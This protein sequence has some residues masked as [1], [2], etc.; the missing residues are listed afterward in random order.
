MHAGDRPRMSGVDVAQVIEGFFRTAVRRAKSDPASSADTTRAAAS[1]SPAQVPDRPLNRTD[2]RC[3][4]G[5]RA[6][7]PAR[8][9]SSP[10]ALRAEFPYQRLGP[11]RLAGARGPG[12]EDVLAADDG[13]AHELPRNYPTVEAEQLTFRRIE[14]ARA[15]PR[16]AKYAAAA[17]VPSIDQTASLGRRIAIATQPAAGRRRNHDLYRAH[18]S[19]VRPTAAVRSRRCADGWRWRAS[20][21]GALH[22]SKSANASVLAAPAGAGLDECLAGAIDAQLHDAAI[23][24]QRHASGRSVSV[25]AEVSRSSPSMR[26]AAM[27]SS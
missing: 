25:S 19:A 20:L 22:H 7:V 27:R 14:A 18:R 3:S 26:T 8:P 12:D 17:Q 5:D 23:G 1:A 6:S 15:G 16:V 11:G 9:R 4:D 13:Q 2:A 21:R 10:G 24:K